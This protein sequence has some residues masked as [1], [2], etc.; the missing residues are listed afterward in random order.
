MKLRYFVLVTAVAAFAA[1]CADSPTASKPATHKPNHEVMAEAD[2][3]TRGSGGFGT[4][5]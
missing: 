3:T 4:S 5:H 2:T 1:A